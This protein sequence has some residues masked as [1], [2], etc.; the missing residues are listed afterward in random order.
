MTVPPVLLVTG[1]DTDVGKTVV[2]AALAACLQRRGAV[3][4]YKPVQTGVAPGEPGDV[5]E[6]ARLVRGVTV[7]EGFRLDEPL[8]PTTAAR[9]AGAVLPAVADHA[10][11][12]A[13]LARSHATVVVEG[14]GGLLVGLDNDGLGL[15]EL[16]AC[17]DL[18]FAVVVVVRAGLGTLNHSALSVEALR[19]RGLPTLGLV[20]G[21]WPDSPDLAERCNLE[22]LASTTGV[23]LLGRVPEG[24]GSWTCER[25]AAAAPQWFAPPLRTAG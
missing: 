2:T 23:A 8:A 4:V 18:D 5:D 25:F 6:V 11:T 15:T 1:T 20:I 3:A 13:D 19:Q 12:V 7:R 21:S 14:A 9:R 10:A 22:D 16:A 24:A 17:L